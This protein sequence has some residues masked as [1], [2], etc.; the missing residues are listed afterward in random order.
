MFLFRYVVVIFLCKEL[1]NVPS[2]GVAFETFG[3]M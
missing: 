2:F 3:F 1:L